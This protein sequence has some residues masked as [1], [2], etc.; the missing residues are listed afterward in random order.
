METAEQ[1]DDSGAGE[2][3]GPHGVAV[4]QVVR[5]VAG[6]TNDRVNVFTGAVAF[7][8]EID[9]GSGWAL[10]AGTSV[11]DVKWQPAAAGGHALPGA[12]RA[13][14]PHAASADASEPRRQTKRRCGTGGW[15]YQGAP[16]ELRN[17]KFDAAM[18]E[19]DSEDAVL[20]RGEYKKW[21]K[22]CLQAYRKETQQLVQELDKL[23]GGDGPSTGRRSMV[24]V[25]ED[26]AKY[27][28][29]AGPLAPRQSAQSGAQISS[30]HPPPAS[31][32]VHHDGGLHRAALMNSTS[33]FA[34]ELENPWEWT[35]K[36]IGQGAAAFFRD[37]PVYLPGTTILGQSLAHMLRC[38]DLP[39]ARQ[40]WDQ[41]LSASPVAQGPACSHAC[42]HAVD[43]T[44]VAA[45]RAR[46]LL[47]DPIQSEPWDSPACSKHGSTSNYD[48]DEPSSASLSQ[49][50]SGDGAG[51]EVALRS[52]PFTAYY[53]RI[54]G[55]KIVN[56]SPHGTHP[57]CQRVFL[58]GYF[59]ASPELVYMCYFG[60][61]HTH[62][63]T[64]TH[65]HDHSYRASQPRLHSTTRLRTR[66]QRT[67]GRTHTSI[68]KPLRQPPPCHF[69]RVIQRRVI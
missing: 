2:L 24:L 47:A 10:E 22:K 5:P 61:Y 66:G 58:T 31:T 9:D 57:S 21:R 15:T 60:Y 68:M 17:M 37:A 42:L 6:S 4:E 63:H 26:T 20:E 12:P 44:A 55:V 45:S 35:I 54:E 40:L 39:L 34:V 11:N 16:T 51:G 14:E 50:G 65:T 53:R 38:D 62:T 48:S 19:Q 33:I 7:L 18:Q 28:R 52:Q 29:A 3:L 8:D 32:D 67:D 46:I 36:A 30:S 41:A 64:H 27:L 1:G 25:L 59:G 69:R 43:F 13:T 49:S 56:L 23:T